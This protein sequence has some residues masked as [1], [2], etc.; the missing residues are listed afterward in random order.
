MA[1]WIIIICSQTHTFTHFIL[2]LTTLC[3]CVCMCVCVCVSVHTV[4]TGAAAPGRSRL[5]LQYGL[6]ALPGRQ[7]WRGLQE[8]HVCHASARIR[9]RWSSN[10]YT[11]TQLQWH[12]L[13]YMF[14]TNFN[15]FKRK[16]SSSQE[17]LKIT[18]RKSV[19]FV[20]KSVFE[21]M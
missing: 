10:R 7:I 9:A 21:M 3:V 8:V 11:P 4:A 19:Q 2:R 15:H 20:Q 16:W 17:N 13:L 5:R 14:I 6:F 1:V 18:V 12:W